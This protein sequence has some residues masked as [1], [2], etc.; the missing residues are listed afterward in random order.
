[1]PTIKSRKH[2]HMYII[3]TILV[4]LITVEL[5]AHVPI[6]TPNDTLETFSAKAFIDAMNVTS[7]TQGIS[8]VTS[9]YN[10]NAGF[11]NKDR[12]TSYTKE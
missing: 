8:S 3:I 11:D 7:E 10:W 9:A 1:M 12:V 5:R 2:V 4:L 6:G